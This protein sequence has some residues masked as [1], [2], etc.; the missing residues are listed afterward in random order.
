MRRKYIQERIRPYFIFGKSKD[1]KYVDIA[2]SEDSTLIGHITV[3]DAEKII[4]ERDEVL[5]LLYELSEECE[6]GFTSVWYKDIT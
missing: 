6:Y 1:G 2:T 4:K 5:E 3:E